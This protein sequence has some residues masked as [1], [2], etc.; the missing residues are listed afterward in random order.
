VPRQVADEVAHAFVIENNRYT[1]GTQKNS[2]AI[3]LNDSPW[4]VNLK[5][6]SV[7]KNNCERL[8]RF[9]RHER[10]HRFIEEFST[11]VA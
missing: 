9:A 4:T 7:Y 10:S 6:V 11:H 2:S 5:P 3:P 8:K 1:T